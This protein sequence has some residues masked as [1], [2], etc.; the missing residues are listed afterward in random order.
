MAI[1]IIL[2]VS[3]AQPSFSIFQ[4]SDSI[5]TASGYALG[6]I[7]VKLTE[8][9]SI[10]EK[11]KI[12]NFLLPPSWDW[13]NYNG[14]NWVT[15][16]KNQGNCGS[17]WDFAA[18][19]ALESVI[20]IEEGCADFNP[21]LSEQY[22]L[23]CPPDSGGCNGWDAYLAYKYIYQ[24][25][26]ALLESCFP[27]KADDK[28]PCS[29]KCQDWRENLVPISGYGYILH[30]S[31]DY[32]KEFLI[33]NGPFVVDMTVYNDFFSYHGGV[34]EHPGNEPPSHINH[35]V[36]L[37]GY[38][39]SQQC[40]ICKNS[41]GRY[42]GENGFFRIKY[43][44]CQ[45]EYVMIYAKYNPNNFNWPPVANAGGIYKGHENEEITFNGSKSFDPDGDNISYEWN[46]GD[47]SVGYGMIVKH[48]YA[49]DGIYT[50]TLTV[51]DSKGHSNT[52]RALVYIDDTPPIVKFNIPRN[53]YIYL[54]NREYRNPLWFLFNKPIVI[55]PLSI[56]VYAKDDSLMEKVQ[57]YIDGKMV[58][59]E[60]SPPYLFQWENAATGKH[61]IKAI[62]YD[63]VGNTNSTNI[64][65]I[66]FA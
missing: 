6:C 1:I 44:D 28:I 35:Q 37:V 5:K 36:V 8:N 64:T 46:F 14:K 2:S 20:K 59:E 10:G 4:K 19:G 41:W 32:M 66:R 21:D 42:W 23:S 33:E 45:I 7:P 15:P 63:V 30:P 31:R 25:G 17:C 52:D 55:G 50:V 43:G 3:I 38:N 49:K 40:W 54:F 65:V 57:F 34:Y 39:D 27:Y 60:K 47:G 48:A 24:H 53:G 61:E 13:R 18:M 26:G 56:Y 62:A 22:L 29:N 58:A 16:V 12:S 11:P 9:I 51:I